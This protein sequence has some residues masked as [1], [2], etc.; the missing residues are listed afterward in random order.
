MIVLANALFKDIFSARANWQFEAFLLE[1]P[2]EAG[3]ER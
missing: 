3:S 2:D 1:M